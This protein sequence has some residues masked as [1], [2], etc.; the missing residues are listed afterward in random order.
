MDTSAF[1]GQTAIITGGARGFGLGIARRLAMQQCKIIIW[2][3]APENFD[4]KTAGFEPLALEKVDV[5]RREEVQAAFASALTKTKSVEILITSAGV[6]GPN[7]PFWD[8]PE[9]DFQRVI[10]IDL[11]GVFHCCQAVAAHMHERGYGRILNIASIAGKEGNPGNPAYSSAKA[12]VIALTKSLGKELAAT[13]K[14]IMVNSLAP[15]MAATDLLWELKPEVVERLKNKI[16]MGRFLEIDEVAAL[17]AWACSREC[18]FTTGFCFD[19]S[20]GRA[21]Y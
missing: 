21:T 10:A 5:T 19:L 7:C 14:N 17:V 2:D 13:G 4:R 3:I 8:Y 16:P 18:S 9:K 1:A 20:G 12:G 15:A 11:M 6:T